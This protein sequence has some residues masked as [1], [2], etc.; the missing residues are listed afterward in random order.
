MRSRRLNG[1]IALRVG[2]SPL[3]DCSPPVASSV[4]PGTGDDAVYGYDG[5]DRRDTKTEA[6]ETLD[7]SYRSRELATLRKAASEGSPAEVRIGDTLIQHQPGLPA[8]G[9]TLFGEKGFPL[10]PKAFGSEPELASTIAQAFRLGT[11]QSARGVSGPMA[12]SETRSA[13]TFAQKV[14]PYI[15]RR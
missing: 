2:S 15:W 11:S 6:G 10:G 1:T 7:H 3:G 9:M 13:F 4:A 12:L 8:S 5:P 14:E